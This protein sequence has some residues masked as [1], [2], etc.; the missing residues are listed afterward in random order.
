MQVISQDGMRA[1]FYGGAAVTRDYLRGYRLTVFSRGGRDIVVGHF[2]NL[3]EAQSA[4]KEMADLDGKTGAYCVPGGA[5]GS[6]SIP[7]AAADATGRMWDGWTTG[8]L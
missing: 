1:C 2:K 6:G 5:A 8:G 3:G 7:A 4:L